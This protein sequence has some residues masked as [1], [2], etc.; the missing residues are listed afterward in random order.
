MKTTAKY[1]FR[2]PEENDFVSVDDLNYNVDEIE[3]ALEELENKK[4]NASGGDI[5]ETV[6][7]VEEPSSLEDKY[8]EISG[9]G[10]TKTALGKLLRWVKSLKA[11]KVDKSGGDIAD[12]K[13]A[14]LQASTSQYPV[15]AAG[16]TT[17]VMF[18]KVKKF[19]EDIRNTATGAC[20]IGQIVNNCVTNRADLPLSAAQGKV[21]MDLYT[22]LNANSLKHADVITQYNKLEIRN[23]KI[24]YGKME[25]LIDYNGSASIVFPDS[26]KSAD[27]YCCIPIPMSGAYAVR[28]VTNAGENTSLVLLMDNDGNKPEYHSKIW[29][30]Y[31]VMGI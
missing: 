15:P 29:M 11:D 13:V 3:K 14:S 21:L 24:Q 30:Q 10:S 16:D 7:T 17:K 20:Y 2:K 23:V 12:T 5:S 6:T 22:V 4:A 19:F 31:I 8:P 9:K 18:G 28:S 1:G 25:C 26:Y 27:L